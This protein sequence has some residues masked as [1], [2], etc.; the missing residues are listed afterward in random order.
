MKPKLKP[1]GTKRL[2]VKR[3][4]LLSTSAFKFNLRRYTKAAEAG[5]PKAMFALGCCLDQG[6][7]THTL[8]HPAAAGWY[9]QGLGGYCSPRHSTPFEDSSHGGQGESLMPLHTR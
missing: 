3:D 8:D 6:E 1:P 2:K 5:L 7:G 4:M 9:K